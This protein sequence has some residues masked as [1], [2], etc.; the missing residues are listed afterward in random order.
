[1]PIFPF[2]TSEWLPGFIDTPGLS[3]HERDLLEL[4]HVTFVET[5]E[6]KWERCS[7]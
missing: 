5:G 2:E 3:D 4:L 6:A 7:E 1:M